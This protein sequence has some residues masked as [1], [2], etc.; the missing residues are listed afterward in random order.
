MHDKT[1]SDKK[2]TVFFNNIKRESI[3][4]RNFVR[5]AVN[6]ALRQIGKRNVALNEA[7]VK[8]AEE[9]LQ[10]DSKSAKW[11]ANDA[12]RELKSEAIRKRFI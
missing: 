9:I 4:E 6:W 8:L 11:I 5:K 10:I 2:F 3:D 1:A 7:A 12:L